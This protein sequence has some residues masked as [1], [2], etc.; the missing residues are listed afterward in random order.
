LSIIHYP[1]SIVNY[2]LNYK[3]PLLIGLLFSMLWATAS[4]VTKI[5]LFSAQPFFISVVRFFLAGVL[6]LIWAHGLRHHALPK[7][8]DWVPLMIYGVL[9]V[10]IYLGAFVLAMQEVAAGIGTLGVG[11]SPLWIAILSALW[12]GKTIERR[13]WTGLLLGVAG[14][15]M[16]VWPL[17]QGSAATP[18]G[19]FFLVCALFSYAAGTIYYS[20][21]TWQ[22]P[23]IVINGW[24]VLFGG[25]FLL[26]AA[27]W[28][29][30]A[31][32]N[33]YDWRF[34]GS[35]AWLVLAVSV[36]AV[37]LWLYLLRLDEVK[38]A[39]W[40][41]LCPIFGFIY[42]NIFLHEPIS[43]WTVAGTALVIT[44]LYLGRKKS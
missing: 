37:Q 33:H 34:W 16:A 43:A 35:V 28:Y 39:L 8:S 32:S 3:H 42:A 44:G 4:V 1:L 12:L 21:R 10:G 40:L 6:M 20:G 29:F 5:G 19:L 2:Q 27:I 23:R 24:Q 36:L 31:D 14:V 26:P 22:L 41:F 11:T 30:D 25:L 13:V 9:N 7:R 17:L 38:A 18:R 15:V